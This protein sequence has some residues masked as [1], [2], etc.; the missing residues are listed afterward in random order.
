MF[1]TLPKS[2]QDLI[3]SGEYLLTESGQ[4]FLF[5]HGTYRNTRQKTNETSVI[6][7]SD[8]GL[9]KLAGSNWWFSDGTFDTSVNFQENGFEQFYIIHGCYKN[10]VL[11][12][13]FA[14]L[15]NKTKEIYRNLISELKDRAAHLKLKLEP[16]YVVLDFEAAAIDAYLFCNNQQ[17]RCSSAHNGFI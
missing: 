11:A 14:L 6:Y 15:T 4:K 13:V 17:S 7:C 16:Q 8:V 10:I 1:P 9:S 12:C 5:S 3:I 2:L